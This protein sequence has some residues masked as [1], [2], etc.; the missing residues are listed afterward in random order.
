M[1][2]SIAFPFYLDCRLTN[3]SFCFYKLRYNDAQN[4]LEIALCLSVSNLCL[5]NLP[6]SQS[7]VDL[8]I[9][10]SSIDLGLS[11]VQWASRFRLPKNLI[12]FLDIYI[13][14]IK[15]K[16]N[17]LKKVGYSNK[18]TFSETSMLIPINI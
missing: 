13:Y 15:L 12:K 11:L 10:Q 14:T 8:G 6:P 5:P 2:P 16:I 9:I 17:H 18:F 7:T 1:L 4:Q 3:G